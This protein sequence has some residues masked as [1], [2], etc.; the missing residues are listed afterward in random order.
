LG[1]PVMDVRG[2][3]SLPGSISLAGGGRNFI[4]PSPASSVAGT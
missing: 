1:D 3:E 2:K 4:A